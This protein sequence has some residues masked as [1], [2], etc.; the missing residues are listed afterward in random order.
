MAPGKSTNGRTEALWETKIQSLTTPVLVFATK[1]VTKLANTTRPSQLVLDASIKIHEL[2]KL[3]LVKIK[4]WARKSALSHIEANL[5][6]SRSRRSPTAPCAISLSQAIL[7]HFD[8][9]RYHLLQEKIVNWII[10]T[11]QRTQRGMK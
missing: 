10:G 3:S 9:R 2:T 6:P 1:L 7:A 8:L 11:L 4:C 5:I